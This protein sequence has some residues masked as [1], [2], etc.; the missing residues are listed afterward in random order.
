VPRGNISS[1]PYPPS[2]RAVHCCLCITDTAVNGRPGFQSQ[3]RFCES[4]EGSYRG[5]PGRLARYEALYFERHGDGCCHFIARDHNSVRILLLLRVGSQPRGYADP[6][7]TAHVQNAVRVP[8][9]QNF[10]EVSQKKP[11]AEFPRFLGFKYY[12]HRS[13]GSSH[14]LCLDD[15]RRCGVLRAQHGILKNLCDRRC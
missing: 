15:L 5:G 3:H 13:D 1:A 2:C 6:A 9:A 11:R 10:R 12:L 4:G 7:D 14:C 8:H